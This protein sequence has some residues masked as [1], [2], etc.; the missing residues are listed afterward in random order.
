[1]N[2]QFV[3][4]CEDASKPSLAP[5]YR[6][7]YPYLLV[8][9]RRKFFILQIGTRVDSVSL[10]C[11]NPV[12]SDSPV[13]PSAPP[14]QG[15]PPFRPSRRPPERAS[16][17][18]SSFPQKKKSVRFLTQADEILRQVLDRRSCFALT[19]PYLQGEGGYCGGRWYLRSSENWAR[20]KYLI[21]VFPLR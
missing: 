14:F 1:M 18:K 16:A 19:P 5:L 9:W 8:E 10:D 15:R 2:S 11:L 3:F 6:E 17:V 12:I 7:P 4:V 13:T 21:Y 20:Q